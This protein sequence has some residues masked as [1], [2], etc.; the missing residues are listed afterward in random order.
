LGGIFIA[1]PAYIQCCG[2]GSAGICIKLIDIQVGSGSG[3]DP[4]SATGLIRIRK[5]RKKSGSGYGFS[6]YGSETL[7]LLICSRDRNLIVQYCGSGKFIQNPGSDFLSSWIPDP[8][9][10]IPDPDPHQRI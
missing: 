4:Y 9:F 10:K 5:F 3:M 7:V 2:S 8:S 1:N 6:E